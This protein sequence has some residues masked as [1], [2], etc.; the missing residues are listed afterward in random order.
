MTRAVNYHDFKTR[1]SSGPF[2]C[3]FLLAFLLLPR[4]AAADPVNLMQEVGID[5]N[6]DAQIPLDAEFY[7]ESGKLVPLRTFCRDK[8][9]VLALVYFKCPMLCGLEIEGLVR[10]LRAL[11]LDVGKDFDVLVVSFDPAERAE[12]AAGKKR[13]VLEHYDREGSE[14]GFHFLTGDEPSIRRLTETVGFRYK[15]D[16]ETRQFA[17]AAGIF[18]LTP[19]GRTSRYFYGVDYPPRD[20]RLGLVEASQGTIGTPT[21][22]ILLFCYHYDPTT[23]KYGFAILNVLRAAGIATV[24]AIAASIVAMVRRDRRKLHA[25][26]LPASMIQHGN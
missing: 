1:K 15:F 4:F 22:R 8:P 21:D 9:V 25:S 16:P 10:S 2:V 7:D 24:F 14:D 3:L 19:D 18:V 11:S 17:H 13:S 5:Q 20:L 26:L 6:L 12:L 23:G